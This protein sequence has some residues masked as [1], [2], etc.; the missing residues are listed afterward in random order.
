MAISLATLNTK[1]GVKPPLAVFYGVGGVGKTTLAAGSNAPVF[2]WTED[3]AGKLDVPGWRVS[4]FAE[5]TEAV[6]VLYTEEHQFKTLVVDSLDWLETLVQAEAC[7]RNGWKH[8]EEP[9]YGKG[10]VAAL[11]VWKDYLEGLNALR[12]E[13][14]MTIIQI[15]HADIK[16]FDNPESEPYDRYRI[17]LHDRAAGLVQEHADLVG[18]L[19][20]RVS[21]QKADV[22][23]NKK[24]NRA[25][26]GGQRVL[27]L[28]ERPAF[29]AK[30]RYGMPVSIDL[31]T[32]AQAWE[33]PAAIW[34]AVAQ[35]LPEA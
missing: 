34:A 26:G 9:G 30:N 23:F 13:R 20:Y 5:V 31:P 24:V 33:N 3:G 32:T 21:L 19:N 2:I 27:Y 7:A 4:S 29:H 15:A 10:Y 28:E 16:R 22:G 11:A 35:H 18:F 8:I 6:G 25:V 17:K 1:N 12:D 14:G